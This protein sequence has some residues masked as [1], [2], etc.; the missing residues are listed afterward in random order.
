M[1]SRLAILFATSLIAVGWFINPPQLRAQDEQR[2]TLIEISGVESSI[3]QN[4]ES[5]LSI[6]QG[7]LPLSPLGFPRSNEYIKRKTVS[8]LRALGYYQPK[9]ELS[10]NH[11][12]WQLNIAAGPPI[13][14][15]APN[16]QVSG[17]LQPLPAFQKLLKQQPFAVS[18]PMNHGVY[19]EF[20]SKLQS[21]AEEY[22]FL[23]AKFDLSELTIDEKAL[24]AQV[25]WHFNSGQRYTLTDVKYEGS[26]LSSSFLSGFQSVQS[27]QF[28]QQDSLLKT[29]QNLNQSGYF[30]MVNID[31]I[32][33]TENKTVSLLFNLVDMERYELKTSLG[34]GTDSGY[35][36]GV[37]WLDRQVNEIGHKYSLGLELNQLESSI[38]GQ[39]RVPLDK[40][41][42]EW[43]N[44]VSYKIRDDRLAKTTLATYE[45]IVLFKLSDHWNSQYALTTAFEEVRENENIQSHISYLVPSAQLDYYSVTNP[46]QAESGWRW[47]QIYRFGHQS[48]SSPGFNFIQT[49]QKLK[50]IWSITEDWR[51]MLRTQIGYTSMDDQDFVRLMPTSY[52]FFAGGDISVRGYDFQSLGSADADSKLIGGKHLLTTTA[53]LDWRFTDNFRW[54]IFYDHGNAFN[55]WKNPELK[56]SAGTGLR[57]ITPFGSF[58]I[59]YARSLDHP[60]EW[61]WHVTIGPDL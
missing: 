36:F 18:T 26:H 31:R 28:Y 47:Q 17:G 43:L 32:I 49:E 55:D 10:G 39:Y 11:S 16:I 46:F 2:S 61:R 25:N 37:N 57:W 19:S 7:K 56:S 27:G 20:K 41:T 54:A 34:Y 5:H 40:A 33:D 4:I 9:I 38:S 50:K 15:L 52:R 35:K 14:W 3:K 30:R 12:Q 42:D 6:E 8:A 13:R 48:L 21:F 44:R 60:N 58:R 59:D 24:T 51:F 23:D 53:E 29:Q 1:S 45:S 22:G